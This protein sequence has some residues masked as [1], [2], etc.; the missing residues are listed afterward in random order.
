MTSYIRLLLIIFA[1]INFFNLSAKET[2]CYKLTVSSDPSIKT[3][4]VQFISFIGDQCYES[5]YNGIKIH[6]G[7]LNKNSYLSSSNKIVYT[8]KCFCG[9]GAKFE[10]S[11]DK[12]SLTVISKVGHYFRF[13]KI[14]PPKGIKTCDYVMDDETSPNSNH[15]DGYGAGTNHAPAYNSSSESYHNNSSYQTNRHTSQTA[16]RKCAYC[17]GT[18]RIEKNDNA[19]ASFGND[20]PKQK[21][22]ECGKW[23]DPDVFTHY[24]QQCRHCDGTGYVK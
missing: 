19:P 7:K 16:P 1:A 22:T 12:T 11:P 23:Y 15:Y 4:G 14:F 24:H 9:S 2:Y 21:C 3:G 17:N 13:I 10:F 20:R 5:S 6:E 8:G 18:G